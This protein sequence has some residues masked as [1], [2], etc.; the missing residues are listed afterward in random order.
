MLPYPDPTASPSNTSNPPQVARSCHTPSNASRS[1]AEALSPVRAA[2]ASTVWQSEQ[3][4]YRSTY[5][6]VS[7]RSRQLRPESL[8]QAGST[9]SETPPRPLEKPRQD[10]QCFRS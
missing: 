5:Q 3:N 7:D 8:C 10:L 6:A 9:T 4:T 2:V 1:S